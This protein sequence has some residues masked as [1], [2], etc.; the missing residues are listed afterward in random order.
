MPPIP[1]IFT[2]ILEGISALF[3]LRAL[4]LEDCVVAE[5]SFKKVNEA[6]PQPSHFKKMLCFAAGHSWFGF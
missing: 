2:P 3:S 1:G 6:R 5:E 4:K